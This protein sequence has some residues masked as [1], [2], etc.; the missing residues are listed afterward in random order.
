MGI[1][2]GA[3]SCVLRA[4]RTQAAL[5]LVGGGQ[6]ELS[7][8]LMLLPME[9]FSWAPP[10]SAHASFLAHR[11]QAKDQEPLEQVSTHPD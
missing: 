4:E 11:D 8:V 6:G 9:R 1:V 2:P 5:G 10:A 3:E 7:V